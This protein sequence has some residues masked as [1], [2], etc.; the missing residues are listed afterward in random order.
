MPFVTEELIP[1]NNADFA[2]H[3]ENRNRGGYRSVAD[4]AARDSIPTDRRSLGMLVRDLDTGVVYRKVAPLA[5]N[6]ASWVVEAG[7]AARADFSLYREADQNIP[8]AET[9]WA[10]GGEVYLLNDG[11]TVD[12]A[13]GVV[14]APSAGRYE[15]VASGGRSLNSAFS[16][17]IWSAIR[18]FRPTEATNPL[19]AVTTFR[20]IEIDGVGDRS[21]G[22][23]AMTAIVDLADGEGFQF[24]AN[25]NQSSTINNVNI[26]IKKLT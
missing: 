18:H 24:V 5:D 19:V 25:G 15:V 7:P 9:P 23:A 3:D 8:A 14:T 4:S 16:G 1:K 20:A 10:L 6:G 12:A 17:T 11:Y 2:T 13:N 22:G 21:G 26:V